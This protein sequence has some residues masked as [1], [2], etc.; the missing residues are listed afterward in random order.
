[1]KCLQLALKVF[2]TYYDVRIY[3][4]MPSLNFSDKS[5]VE[6][7]WIFTTMDY[8]GEAF[9]KEQIDDFPR[10]PPIKYEKEQLQLVNRYL[11][12][13]HNYD[14]TILKGE[15]ASPHELLTLERALDVRLVKGLSPPRYRAFVL[16]DCIGEGFLSEEQAN[17]HLAVTAVQ[18]KDGIVHYND[19]FAG[20]QLKVYGPTFYLSSFFKKKRLIVFWM[21]LNMKSLKSYRPRVS[22]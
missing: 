17:R 22:E 7:E 13:K 6:R 21:S 11:M 18:T 9:M 15:Q 4:R 10:T 5:L 19:T 3:L 1:M 12:M 2:G 14:L 20:K 8:Y 16:S